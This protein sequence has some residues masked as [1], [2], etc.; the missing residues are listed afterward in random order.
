MF[1]FFKNKRDTLLTFVPVAGA[2]SF[3]F[4]VFWI[5]GVKVNL[6]VLAFLPLLTGLGVDYGLFQVIKHR[7]GQNS[8]Y[9][10]TA[11]VAA[12]LSTWVG[13]GVLALAQHPVLF[14]MGLSACLGIA[15]AGL[16]ALFLLP[17]LLEEE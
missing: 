16:S 13:F 4:L 11:L 1:Y 9:P 7:G 12:A 3:T 2:F 10:Q 8:L 6:F 5:S 17:P 14:I 15:G